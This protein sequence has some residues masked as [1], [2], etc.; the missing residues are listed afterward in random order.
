[1]TKLNISKTNWDLSPL[2]SSDSDPKIEEQKKQVTKESYQFI[3][4]WKDRHDYLSDPKIIK[5][6]LDE[7]ENWHHH[8]GTSGDFGYYFSLRSAQDQM[9][10][11]IKAKE[12]QIEDFANKIQNDIQFFEMRISKIP[13]DGQQQFLDDA[14]LAPYKHYLES[15]FKQSKYLLSE[16]EEKILNLKSSTSHSNWVKMTSTFL[17]KEEAEVIMED[18]TRQVKNFSEIVTLSANKNKA[19]RDSAAKA[20]NDVN[21][22][23]A[24]VAENEINS[25]LTNKKTTDELRGMER[26]D[27]GR[28]LADDV[29][30]EVV[31]SLI[32]A[33]SSRNNIPQRFYQLKSKLMGQPK[34]A[35]HER[36]VEYGEIDKK[37]SY[38]EAVDLVYHVFTQLDPKFAEIAKMFVETGK[39]DALPQKGKSGGAFSAHHL[40]SQPT[41]TLLN[42]TELLNDVLT[43]AH[44]FGHG[45]NNELMREKQN[46]LNFGTPTST[47]EVAST[48]MEDFVL[49]ELLKESDDETKLAIMMMKLNDDVSSIFRQVACYKFEQDLHREFR[50]KGYLSKE[51]IGA[52][53]KKNMEAYMGDFVEQ[54]DGSQN[55]WVYWSHIRSF[56]YVYSYASGLLISKSLQGSVK[57]DHAFIEKVKGFLA[58]GT[59]DSPKNIFS[60]MNVNIADKNFWN[61]GLDE[62]ETL[63]KETEELAKK[64]KKI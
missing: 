47:A 30:T 4:K 54:S 58:S 36:N 1:M 15:L 20:F 51:D 31:D 62:I 32:D 26:P 6:A 63:L 3:N 37:Y 43:I 11:E 60:K 64:L 46:A 40:K 23:W 10:T 14:N 8:Y 35:Y 22:K 13:K 21:A 55:W 57:E 27:T 61:K 9:S 59:S 2:L 48:F 16:P 53:F 56:F 45:I 39:I 17:S 49:Q 42:F 38:Q 44:E 33:V 5:E 12:N 19:T 29:E 7:Y 24:E 41:Y 28:H 18:G 50:E 52:L 25:I 34:L